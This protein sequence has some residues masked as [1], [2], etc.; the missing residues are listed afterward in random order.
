M[1]QNQ[2]LP[3]D[4]KHPKEP[5]TSAPEE[6]VSLNDSVTLFTDKTLNPPPNFTH[7]RTQARMSPSSVLALQRTIG[8]QATG[9]LV[10]QK[11]RSA[12]PV[13]LPIQRSLS[14]AI[15]QDNQNTHPVGANAGL[16]TAARGQWFATQVLDDI[17]RIMQNPNFHIRND[18]PAL[19]ATNY[20]AFSIIEYEIRPLIRDGDFS[21]A[22]N[23]AKL[24]EINGLLNRL[25]ESADAS[26]VAPAN[27]KD[28]YIGNEFTFVN[29]ALTNLP[30]QDKDDIHEQMKEPYNAIVGLW[31]AAMTTRG[32]TPVQDYMADGLRKLKYTFAADRHGVAWEYQVTPD[33]KCVEIITEKAKASDIYSGYVG[34]LMDDF[35]FGVANEINLSAHALIGGG[36]INVDEESAFGETNTLEQSQHAA[37]VL[38]NFM[39]QFYNDEKYWK[40]IDPDSHNSPFPSE[41]ETTAKGK[42]KPK[43]SKADDFQKIILEFNTHHWTV[44]Q[45]ADQLIAR[46]FNISNVSNKANE[47]PHYQA[48]N[49]EHLKTLEGQGTRRLE[50]RRVPAQPDRNA[51]LTQL[52]KIEGTLRIAKEKAG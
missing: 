31:H 2:I 19:Q 15:L 14:Y 29:D 42:D 33:Q 25:E 37:K 36:H 3:L 26:K 8:N 48:L 12:Q 27:I 41:L 43:T 28:T 24:I 23:E 45:L 17:R 30:G 32:M 16:Q 51:L 34:S 52:S 47:A 6:T 38:A 7:T 49:I 46:V 22:L 40:A 44:K 20:L 13:S 39:I 21:L 18:T 5:K 35:V 9:R 11:T 50:V 4:N 10:K 1:T